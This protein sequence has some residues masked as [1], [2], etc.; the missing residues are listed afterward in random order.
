MISDIIR[1]EIIDSL[2]KAFNSNIQLQF[3]PKDRQSG[4]TPQQAKT[5]RDEEHRQQAIADIRSDP[6]VK[7][8]ERTIGAELIESSVHRLDE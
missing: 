7:K 5:R 2:S 8:L 1:G 6:L 4:E 3:K